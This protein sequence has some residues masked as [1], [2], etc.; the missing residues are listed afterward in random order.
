MIHKGFTSIPQM[1]EDLF[2]TVIEAP[3]EPK[4]DKLTLEICLS[5]VRFRKQNEKLKKKITIT[6]DTNTA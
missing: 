2:W 1:G 5:K 6:S 3:I 4:P